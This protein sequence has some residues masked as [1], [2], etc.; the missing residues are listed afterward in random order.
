MADYEADG[1]HFTH[2]NVLGSETQTTDWAGSGGQGILFYPWG[3]TW[4]NPSGK[5]GNPVH[6]VFAS[7][8]DADSST[9]QYVTEFRH[10]P[11]TQGRWLTPDPLAGDITNPQSL[12]RYAYA[13]N[14]PT[15]LI[16]PVGLGPCPLVN[17]V[18][19]PGCGNGGGNDFGSFTVDGM[20][21]SNSLGQAVLAGGF[22]VQCPGNACEFFATNKYGVTQFYQYWA[23]A[24]AA[25]VANGYYPGLGPLNPD[26]V[27]A[28]GGSAAQQN[29][30][31]QR[32]A[33][34]GG[35]PYADTRAG[36][37]VATWQNQAQIGEFGV[38]LN[39]LVG[40]PDYGVPL[41]LWWAQSGNS[42]NADDI[43]QLPDGTYLTG[44]VSTPEGTVFRNSGPGTTCVVVGSASGYSSC[45]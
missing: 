3:Q 24:G 5:F 42:F 8:P 2:A 23:F 6:T 44:W 40:V 28:Y 32:G 22:G 29:P 12:N 21:V 9:G 7:L 25:A 19:P 27:A 17:D 34:I 16:D 18:A 15:A 43:I 13:R 26:A 1:V 10:Y 41:G 31:V 11:P 39:T 45:Q 14:N 4:S 30:D 37:Y 20:A 35:V 33:E 38:F 36:I